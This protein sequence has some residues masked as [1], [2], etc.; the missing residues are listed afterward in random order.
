MSGDSF[1]SDSNYAK[2]YDFEVC[3]PGEN[4]PMI[5]GSPLGQGRAITKEDTS[6][7]CL[8][9]KHCDELY[10]AIERVVNADDINAMPAPWNHPNLLPDFIKYKPA[11]PGPPAKP[12]KLTVNNKHLRDNLKCSVTE[13]H[14]HLVVA[15]GE[16]RRQTKALEGINTTISQ[17]KDEGIK[18]F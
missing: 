14:R 8:E 12:P 7:K 11:K 13:G 5:F 2:T 9:N 18:T 10:A 6:R 16:N 17:I 4:S 1:F 3:Y 15:S